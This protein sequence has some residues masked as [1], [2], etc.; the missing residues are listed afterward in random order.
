[1]QIIDSAEPRQ[2]GAAVTNRAQQQPEIGQSIDPLGMAAPELDRVR[3][4][5]AIDVLGALAAG[6]AQ[7]VPAFIEAGGDSTLFVDDDH[8]AIYVALHFAY[9]HRQGRAFALRCCR[10]YLNSVNL[11]DDTMAAV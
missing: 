4:D 7:L 10:L 3:N 9:E 8:H 11:F 5:A 6:P 1:M 2:W